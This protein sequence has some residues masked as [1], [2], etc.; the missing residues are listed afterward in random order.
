M[1]KKLMLIFSSVTICL[2]GAIPAIG[3]YQTLYE[4]KEYEQLSGKKLEFH[5]AP[6]LRTRVA[7]GEL[8][9]VEER[10]PEEPLVIE[11]F[12]KIGQYGGTL[13]TATLGVN[14]FSE[15]EWGP[16]VSPGPILSLGM[17]AG[18]GPGILKDIKISKDG[19]AMTWDLR[20]GMR[21]S[22]GAP[23][24]AD[25]ILWWFEIWKN[26]DLNPAQTLFSGIPIEDI[27]VKKLSD[28]EIV[29]RFLHPVAAP[30]KTLVA[31][32]SGWNWWYPK[33]YLKKWYLPDNPKADELAK[34]EGFDYWYEAFWEHSSVWTDLNCP[35][36]FAWKRSKITPTYIEYKRNPYY[37]IVDTEGNQLPYID[38]IVAYILSDVETEK[39][40]ALSGDLSYGGVYYIPLKDYPLFKKGAEKGDYHLIMAKNDYTSDYT[41]FFNLTDKDPV[42]REIFQDVRFRRAM[43]MAINR[44]EIN[45]TFYF[46]MGKPGQHNFH[47]FCPWYEEEW[48]KA[49]TEYN[50][51]EANRLLDEMG[52]TERDAAG[53]RLCPDGKPII[54]TIEYIESIPPDATEI[55]ELIEEYWWEVGVKAKIK[56]VLRSLWYERNNANEMSCAQ[57]DTFLT[58]PMQGRG[59]PESELGLGYPGLWAPLWKAWIY[60]DG[61][62]GEEPPEVVKELYE[63]INNWT[64][65]LEGTEEFKKWVKKIGDLWA[66]NIWGIGT[67]GMFPQPLLVKNNL[68]NFPPEEECWFGG[69]TDGWTIYLPAQWFFEK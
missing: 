35:N 30:K 59:D 51:E 2:L 43:S 11:P 23:F 57:W 6:E 63:A 4:L 49:W 55:G 41:L 62:K 61:E 69:E 8:P 38:R 1:V 50:P 16:V 48:G 46:G 54:F 39:M 25:D 3:Q 36:V 20:K 68:K 18:I 19:K 28:Y 42:L 33:H 12:E 5:E 45:N 67:I 66:E 27:E 21:W 22:D 60:S 44:E 7:A 29:F 53:F 40:K 17:G 9:P 15:A 52:L 37:F 58:G 26:K 34:E 64:H 14:S 65:S 47:P 31:A 10:L 32:K 24:T 13:Y 56:S